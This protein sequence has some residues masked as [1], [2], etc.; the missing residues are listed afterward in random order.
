[1]AE[2]L[3]EQITDVIYARLNGEA[4]NVCV[5]EIGPEP[6][7]HQPRRCQVQQLA[8]KAAA[9]QQRPA[10]AGAQTATADSDCSSAPRAPRD[11]WS[12]R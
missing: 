1:M 9:P 3:V 11:P 4:I 2:T 10:P 12:P 5:E 7:H 6:I 8:E